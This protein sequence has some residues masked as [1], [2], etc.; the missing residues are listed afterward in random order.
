MKRKVP[1]RSGEKFHDI[2]SYGP[3]LQSNG[4]SS[5][6]VT[7]DSES[8]GT[9]SDKGEAVAKRVNKRKERGR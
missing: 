6:T 5:D 7:T 9:N 3:L 8:T 2:D 1:K 4:V